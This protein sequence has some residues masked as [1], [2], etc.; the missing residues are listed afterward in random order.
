[1]TY[2]KKYKISDFYQLLQLT[3]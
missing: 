2:V 3:T 1:M